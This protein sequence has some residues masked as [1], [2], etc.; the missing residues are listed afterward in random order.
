MGNPTSANTLPASE[1]TFPE[2]VT[3]SAPEYALASFGKWHLGSG[4]SGPA[5][6]GGWPN[7]TGT[8]QGGV[9][10]YADWVRVKIEN[11]AVTDT[12][13]DLSLIHI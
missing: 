12:G 7:F 11:G 4:E 6:T 13:T 8:I 9:P 2:I 3:A 1:L 10:D 5:D